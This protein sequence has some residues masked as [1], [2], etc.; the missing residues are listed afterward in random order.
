MGTIES[1]A[2]ESDRPPVRIDSYAAFC[3]RVRVT[4]IIT[5]IRVEG[6]GTSM[7]GPLIFAGPTPEDLR[8]VDMLIQELSSSTHCS[9]KAC[10]CWVG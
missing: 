4:A 1:A 3:F 5:A 7:P 9:T 6:L 2:T 8:R 10:F